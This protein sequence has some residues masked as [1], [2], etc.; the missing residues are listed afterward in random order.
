[1]GTVWQWGNVSSRKWHYVDQNSSS[2]ILLIIYR[3]SSISH[4]G[5]LSVRPRF[6]VVFSTLAFAFS[7][8]LLAPL[9]CH[10]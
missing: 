10:S 9:A 2:Y 6:E 4:L 7:C 1:M 8:H 5:P 3:S